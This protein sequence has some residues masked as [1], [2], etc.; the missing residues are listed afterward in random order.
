MSTVQM[1]RP[2]NKYDASEVIPK[3]LSLC[4][5]SQQDNNPQKVS[6]VSKT[7]QHNYC[8]QLLD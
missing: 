4:M 8:P 1:R 5:P 6:H 3:F 2:E 7:S